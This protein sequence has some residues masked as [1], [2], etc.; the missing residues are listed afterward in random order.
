MT[1]LSRKV[2]GRLAI[3][4]RRVDRHPGGEQRIDPR[5]IPGTRRLAQRLALIVG[6]C[7]Q[8]GGE[9][10]DEENKTT[11]EKYGTLAARNEHGVPPEE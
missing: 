4:G 6:A 3:A 7:S 1:L 9:E 11:G 2:E 5:Q 10:N 8:P